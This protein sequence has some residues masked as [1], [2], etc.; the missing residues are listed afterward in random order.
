MRQDP[1]GLQT[2]LTLGQVWR[3]DADTDFTATSGLSGQTSDLLVAGQ[4]AGL[5]GLS[6]IGRALYD[7]GLDLSKAEARIGWQRGSFSLGA[8][9][10]WLG[11]DLAEDRPAPQSEWA[12]DG[13]YEVSR[14]WTA[15]ANL[16]YDV[17]RDETTQAGMGLRYRNECVDLNLSLSRRFTSSAIVAPSTD[18]GF[19]V[20]IRGFGTGETDTRYTRT[21][22]NAPT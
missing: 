19:T 21:C 20:A 18:I 5:G 12:L 15:S 7:G 6:L 2:T 1:G 14:H 10:L 16:R 22:R 4:I 3:E 9:Y 8:A 13:R 17:A 11:T